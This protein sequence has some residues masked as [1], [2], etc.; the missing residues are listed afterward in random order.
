MGLEVLYPGLPSLDTGSQVP[1][2]EKL[3]EH[4]NTGLKTPLVF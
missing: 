3:K 1:K 4:L 2:C